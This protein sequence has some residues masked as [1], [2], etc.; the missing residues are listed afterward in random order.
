MDRTTDERSKLLSMEPM[1][2]NQRV[3]RSNSE[4]VFHKLDNLI[5]FKNH[6][7]VLY[8]GQRFTDMVES[9]RANS[10]M[11]PIVVRPAED[12]KYEILSGHNRVNAAK[13]AGLDSVPALVRTGLT[14]ER[15][16]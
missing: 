6:P 8:E 12:G 1:I 10:I 2:R 16:T 7:F 9:M 15:A 5:P 14:T 11:V 4:I 3:F 13:E